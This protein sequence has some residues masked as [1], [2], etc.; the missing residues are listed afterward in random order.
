MIEKFKL[1]GFGI[2]FFSLRACE[3]RNRYFLVL[4]APRLKDVGAGL[5]LK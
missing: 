3:D 1:R 4:P 5:D 2:S